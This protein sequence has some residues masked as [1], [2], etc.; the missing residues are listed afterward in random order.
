MQY[1]EISKTFLPHPEGL[2]PYFAKVVRLAEDW[3]NGKDQFRI[4]TSGSTGTPKA[5]TIHRKQ[6]L[7][8]IYGTARAFDLYEGTRALCCLNPDYIAGMMMIFRAMELSWTLSITQ[9]TSDPIEKAGNDAVFN[10]TPLVPMQL[11]QLIEKY[12]PDTIA[13][14]GKI[15]LGGGPVSETLTHRIQQLE[16]PT[17]I[18]YGMTETVS[19]V[20][21]KRVNGPAFYND[22]YSLLPDIEAGVDERGC[23][24]L[25]GQVTDHKRL[26]TNDLVEFHAPDQFTWLG[27]I[28]NVINSGG[29]KIALDELDRII[30]HEL[31]TS[32]TRSEFF[33]WHLPDPKL[34]QKL[35]LVINQ[36]YPIPELESVLLKIRNKVHPYKIPKSVYFVK[37]FV[38]LPTGK[39]DKSTTAAQIESTERTDFF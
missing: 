6:I 8:S 23:L 34:G 25:T 29:I 32:G 15:L 9:P 19:H 22:A 33:S 17:Y 24:W 10:F 31:L 30:E 37:H 1:L 21:L 14:L 35:I 28:D 39:L 27:R 38:R 2:D 7:A 4:T 26:Q 16:N 3:L 13:R 11:E 20:A 18:G 12:P 36:E 5:I